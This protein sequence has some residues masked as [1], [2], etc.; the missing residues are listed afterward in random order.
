MAQT[1]LANMVNPEVMADMIDK[2]LVDLMRF[3]PLAEID[4]TLQGRPGDTITLPSF[5][6][7]GDANTLSEGA[8]LNTVVLSTTKA[9]ATIHKVAQGVEI[10]DEAVL[11][12]F[13]DPIGEAV[14]Q[15]ALA[16]ASRVDNEVLSILHAIDANS[17]MYMATANNT[18][19]P[20]ATDIIAGLTLFGEDIDDG[21]TIALVSPAVYQQMRTV[22]GAN[23]WV[24]A[25]EI[26]AGI[27]VRGVVGEFQG[28]QV[29]VSNKLKTT[30]DGVGDI[31]LVKPGALRIFL[32][33]DTLVESSRD[34]LK[35]TTVITASKHFVAYLYNAAKAVRIAKH[36]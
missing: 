34:I 17:P 24:P 19:Y 32:K 11:S 22:S 35:F 28:C 23:A 29:V 20:A 33:R 27:A 7:I 36:E 21:A 13:G 31:F 15:L 6:Y 25:S 12:G 2:K 4:T 8:S 10:T 5:N 1:L 30:G 9:N 18:V 16:I 3:A 14:D 26:A